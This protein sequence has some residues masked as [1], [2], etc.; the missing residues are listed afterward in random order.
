MSASA[1]RKRKKAHIDSLY[2]VADTLK[3]TVR[4]Q[5][6]LIDDIQQENAT[7]RQQLSF[8]HKLLQ[9]APGGKD[10]TQQ[11]EW[12]GASPPIAMPASQKVTS[13]TSSLS[14]S[15]H[16]PV[17]TINGN[18]IVTLL[19]P[20]AAALPLAQGG[21]D[22]LV[23][24][25]EGCSCEKV[26]PG[27]GVGA[28]SP[29]RAGI[30]LFVIFSCF[31]LFNPNAMQ[32]ANNEVAL[33]ELTAQLLNYQYQEGGIMT[34]QQHAR[35]ALLPAVAVAAPADD[36][37]ATRMEDSATVSS[38]QQL[39]G[40]RALQA[41]LDGRSGDEGFFAHLLDTAYL[42][43]VRLVGEATAQQAIRQLANGVLFS[44]HVRQQKQQPQVKVVDVSDGSSLLTATTD[45]AM[46]GR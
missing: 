38:S 11:S 33:T 10:Q 8:I 44:H 30:F 35:S 19:S 2:T 5:S 36:S 41:F 20:D 27:T 12:K 13:S 3:E 16:P 29:Q 40:A 17:A 9:F 15:P 21:G 32:A 28:S 24:T 1:Y 14:S 4:Q 31:L 45:V 22:V 43:L 6:D 18:G 37:T 39:E 46:V 7:L 23:K 26:S 34:P 25:E 42:P